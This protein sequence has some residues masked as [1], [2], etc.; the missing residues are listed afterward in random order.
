MLFTQGDSTWEADLSEG[1]DLSIPVGPLGVRAWGLDAAE[2]R[3]HREGDFVGSIRAGASVNFNDICFNPHAQGTHTECLGHITPEAVPLLSQ[4][5]PAWM[6]ARLVSIAPEEKAGD[7]RVTRGQLEAAL[8]PLRT[9]AVVLRTLPNPES[10]KQAD[11]SGTNP[12]Y[13]E[14]GAA[15]WLKEQGV[16]HLLLDLP[17]VDREQ[18]GGALAAHRGF[19]DIP[20]RPRA[21]ATI[22]ELIYVP[23]Q[24]ADG[25]YALNLQLGPFVND[26]CPSRP[27]LFPLKA[28][29]QQPEVIKTG[30]P[31]QGAT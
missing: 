1:V 23:D 31:F 12:P 2:I 28:V 18:D 22:T 7:Q 26:A 14:E 3:P 27:M 19:W 9:G 13:L 6:L 8:K 17:S 25:L 15:V 5:P 24:V 10:K 11:Y 30:G 29:K 21:D 20:D 16:K 4:P